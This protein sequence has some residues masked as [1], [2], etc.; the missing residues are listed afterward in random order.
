MEKTTSHG[1]FTSLAA[2]TIPFPENIVFIEY[3]QGK[4]EYRFSDHYCLEVSFSQVRRYIIY[5]NLHDKS[6]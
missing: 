2:L 4:C 5:E 3:C 1:I 6:Q